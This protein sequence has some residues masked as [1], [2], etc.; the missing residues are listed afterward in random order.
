M[1]YY[2][3]KFRSRSARVVRDGPQATWVQSERSLRTEV[4]PWRTV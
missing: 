3:D 2:L 4:C 1:T